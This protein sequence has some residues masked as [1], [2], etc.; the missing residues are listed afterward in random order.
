MVLRAIHFGPRQYKYVGPHCRA[1]MYAGRV[2]CCPLVSHGEHA[3]GT[4]RQTSDR[5]ITLS[6][7]RGPRNNTTADLNKYAARSITRLGS[8][9]SFGIPAPTVG[10]NTCSDLGSIVTNKRYDR[11]DQ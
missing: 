11:N 5:N 2:A 8:A 3:D 9:Y 6:A 4:N 1:E 7:R 10:P